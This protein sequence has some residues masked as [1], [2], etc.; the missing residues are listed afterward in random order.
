MDKVDEIISAF[1][2]LDE[3]MRLELLLD[4]ARKLPEPPPE[5]RA[6]AEDEA[7]SALVPECMTP[8]W[9]WVVEDGDRV[10]VHAMVAEE[11]PT[12]QG[13]LSVIVHAYD[14]ASAAQVAGVPRDLVNRL[15]LGKL[16]RMNRAVGIGAIVERIRRAAGAAS[17]AGEAS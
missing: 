16:I 9:L 17:S 1:E 15:G 12:V 5:F 7:S 10:R 4:Y 13:I 6:Q 3:S 14:G 11:A 8:V 2:S